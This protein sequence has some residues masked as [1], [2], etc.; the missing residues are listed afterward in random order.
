LSDQERSLEEITQAAAVNETNIS[1]AYK[2]LCSHASEV[3]PEVF[4]GKNQ[5]DIL[6]QLKELPSI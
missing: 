2:K 4:L 5:K 6:Q 1:R 3:I